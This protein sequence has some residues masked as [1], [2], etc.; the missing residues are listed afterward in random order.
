MIIKKIFLLAVVI[1]TSSF[2][3]AQDNTGETASPQK[4]AR[5]IGHY[6]RARSLLIA[7]IREF[8]AGAK[9]ADPSTLLDPTVWR[10]S[11]EEKAKELERVLDPQP[12]ITSEGV[13]FS[14]DHRLLAPNSNK[15][16]K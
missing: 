5:A 9:I 11:L 15:G 8:D 13:K 14:A 10:S 2:A 1:T 4:T 16:D 12:R 7:A 3:N 6:A